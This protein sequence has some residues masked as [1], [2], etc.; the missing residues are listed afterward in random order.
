MASTETDA[1]ATK[2]MAIGAWQFSFLMR[3]AYGARSP[4]AAPPVR[5]M[6]E[7]RQGADSFCRVEKTYSVSTRCQALF[8]EMNAHS[9]SR[10]ARP[11][12]FGLT[13]ADT[14]SR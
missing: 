4:A 11:S 10:A 13:G 9:G 1:N 3:R 2:A 5:T 7:Q 12:A 6:S 8:V 14:A